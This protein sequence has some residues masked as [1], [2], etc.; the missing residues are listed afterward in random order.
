MPPSC[1]QGGKQAVIT[2][3]DYGEERL[4]IEDR[5]KA[6]T[7]PALVATSTLEL[8]I[9]MGAVDLVILVE[10]LTSVAS[11]LFA[12]VPAT[13]TADV[14]VERTVTDLLATDPNRFYRI[15]VLR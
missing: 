1:D 7:L 8:G 9:D 2:T 12:N 11:G 6:G 14:G 3:Y 10:S 5:L 13:S 15:R 4:I